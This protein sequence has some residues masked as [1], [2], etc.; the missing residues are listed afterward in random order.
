MIRPATSLTPTVISLSLRCAAGSWNVW[1]VVVKCTRYAFC[2]MKPYGR[3]GKPALL[4]LH[5]EWVLKHWV[6]KEEKNLSRWWKCSTN[7]SRVFSLPPQRPALCVTTASKCPI[8]RGRR[9]NMQPRVSDLFLFFSACVFQPCAP[10]FLSLYLS[11]FFAS[12]LPTLQIDLH[13]K[14]LPC[15]A[16]NSPL[17]FLICRRGLSWRPSKP[18]LFSPAR[19]HLRCRAPADQAGKLP[20]DAGQRLSEAAE[21]PRVRGGHHPRGSRLWQGRGGQTG[22]EV[23]V[24]EPLCFS[25]RGMF[26]GN[27]SEEPMKIQMD[28]FTI[29]IGT[30]YYYIHENES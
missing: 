3:R 28:D 17:S 14:S 22:H 13:P 16:Q 9:T 6:N 18:L 2:I 8:R 25:L 24:S 11:I 26:L 19:S 12:P 1:T 15:A 30:I 21:P 29:S 4:L 7:C 10:P 23:Q 20:G 5:H 27:A